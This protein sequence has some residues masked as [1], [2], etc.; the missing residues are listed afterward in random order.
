V[1]A[2]V[3]VVFLAAVVGHLILQGPER[4]KARVRLL[5]SKLR[6]VDR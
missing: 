6:F 2:V 3:G 1:R 5:R 4:G